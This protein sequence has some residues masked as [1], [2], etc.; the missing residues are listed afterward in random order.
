MQTGGIQIQPGPLLKGL[1]SPIFLAIFLQATMKI[2]S[3]KDYSYF[4][5]CLKKKRKC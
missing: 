2:G 3:I 4:M 1:L 5:G